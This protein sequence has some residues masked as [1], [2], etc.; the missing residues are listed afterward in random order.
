MSFKLTF[1]SQKYIILD[2]VSGAKLYKRRLKVVINEA[3]LAQKEK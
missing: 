2:P 3:K 1:K